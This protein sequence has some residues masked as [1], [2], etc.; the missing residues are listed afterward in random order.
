MRQQDPATI[1]LLLKGSVHVPVLHIDI[2]AVLVGDG[3]I[4]DGQI[5]AV[6]ASE[7]KFCSLIGVGR[8]DLGDAGRAVGP[9]G[10]VQ[11]HLRHP[12]GR[13]SRCAEQGY[14]K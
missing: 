12:A 7:I 1:R 8:P 9:Q 6:P 3:K 13:Q 5:A 14:T 4:G 10:H 2:G 11:L